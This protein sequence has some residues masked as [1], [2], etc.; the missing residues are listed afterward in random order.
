MFL[1]AHQ[2]FAGIVWRRPGV[3]EAVTSIEV[4]RWVV[5]CLDRE[6]HG[7][8]AVLGL[9]P[10]HDR[11]NCSV[12]D[13]ATASERR[14][15]IEMSSI[16]PSGPGAVALTIP[17]GSSF[18]VSTTLSATEA[19]RPRHLCSVSPSPVHSA[20]VEPNAAGASARAARRDT[21]QT[22]QSSCD[23][24]FWWITLPICQPTK[25][26]AH[27][28]QAVVTT[29]GPRAISGRCALHRKRRL[30]DGE[31]VPDGVRE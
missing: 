30:L 15:H 13:P 1:L 20:S 28:V 7:P 3:R 27:I 2:S 8:V 22:R 6:D 19:R 18:K 26:A 14:D 11:V 17:A 12:A 10:G 5:V 31:D 9:S 21:R 25:N 29:A 23:S 16:E 24:A 4:N